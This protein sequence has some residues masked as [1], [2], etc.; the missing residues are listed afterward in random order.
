MPLKRGLVRESCDFCFR[1]KVKCDRSLRFTEGFD[2]CSQCDARGEQCCLENPDDIRTQRQKVATSHR[3]GAEAVAIGQRSRSRLGE[4]WRPHEAQ[5][6]EPLEREIIQIS[7]G[8]FVLA[9]L[10]E[11]IICGFDSFTRLFTQTKYSV[12]KNDIMRCIRG[13]IILNSIS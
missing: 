12:T 5:P 7:K 3:K 13:L 4:G 2:T 8:N 9:Q 11:E 1:R 10:F 6:F